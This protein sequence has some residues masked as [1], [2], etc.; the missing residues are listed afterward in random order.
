MLF[1]ASKSGGAGIM[2]LLLIVAAL[3]FTGAG[4][5]MWKR[6]H[7]LRDGCYGAL[8]SAG[9]SVAGP[10]CKGLSRAID[11]GD[12]LGDSLQLAIG[13]MRQRFGLGGTGGSM[14]ALGNSL[15]QRLSGLGSSSDELARLI[16]EGPRALLRGNAAQQLRNGVDSFT[17]GSQ[18]LRQGSTAQA[19]PWLQQG[20]SL[21]SGYGLMSQL[22]LGDLYTR[23]GNGIAPDAAKASIYY[24]QAQQSL[25][26][27]SSSNSPQ[28][29]QILQSLPGSPTAISAQLNQVLGNLPKP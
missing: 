18:F 14:Q 28:A 9:S 5:W 6:M 23:G 27:L 25:S 8:A 17:I 7:G 21:P 2:T 11:A 12:H 1:R 22:S 10:V 16:G 19:L 24:Q 4:S 26:S 13:D 29:Q 20:A 15:Q 3:Y